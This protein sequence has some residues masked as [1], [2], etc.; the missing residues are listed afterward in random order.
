MRSFALLA[1]PLCLGLAAPAR[2][3]TLYLTDGRVLENVTVTSDSLAGVAFKQKGEA[4]QL[5][6]E[7][8]ERVEYQKKPKKIQEADLAL[9]QEDIAGAIEDLELCR[10]GLLGGNEKDQKNFPWAAE[11]TANRVVELRRASQD[12]EGTI[13]AALLLIDNFKE[14]RNLPAAYLALAEAQAAQEREE[15]A[16]ATLASLAKLIGERSLPQRWQLEHDVSQATIDRGLDPK[17]R[18]TKLE[19]VQKEASAKG[20]GVLSRAE[21]AMA[22]AYLQ[23]ADAEKDKREGHLQK[24]VALLEGINARPG[25]EQRILAGTLTGLADAR[26]QAASAAKDKAGLAAARLLYMRVVVLY[27]DQSRYVPKALFYAA[28]IS[29]Q[30][31][32]MTQDPAESERQIKL[33]SRL[34]SRFRGNSWAEEGRTLLR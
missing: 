23:L 1:L 22:E 2:P 5:A 21:L 30:L 12:W 13:D 20:L 15:P 31:F 14:S 10:D 26:F 11:W 34:V 25:V 7:L 32:D 29:K 28:T 24:A 19:R 16:L 9:A 8:V 3:D 18:L 17:A 4:Q 27:R 6:A 33:A